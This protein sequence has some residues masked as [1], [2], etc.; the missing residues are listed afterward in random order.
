ML[1][2]KA[3]SNKVMILGV[4]GFDPKLA[5]KFVDQGIMPNLKK[6]IDQ[7]SCRDDLML[8]GGHP[9]IT[10]P[11]W[12]TLSTGAYATTHGIYGFNTH[13]PGDELDTLSYSLNSYDSKAEPLWDC[14]VEAGKKTLVWHWPGCSWPPTSDSENLFVI[15]GS[16]PGSVGAG[17]LE[18]DSDFLFEASTSIQ[19]IGVI[20][21]DAD[22]EGTKACVIEFEEGTSESGVDVENSYPPKVHLL[23]MEDN[24]KTGALVHN[25]LDV[26]QS[27]ITDAKNWSFEIPKGAKEFVLTMCNGMIRRTGLILKNENGIY[28]KVILYKNKKTEQ[29]IATMIPGQFTVGVVDESY[30]GPNHYTVSRNI[31]VLQ[32]SEDGTY[33]K[34]YVSP[35]MDILS[36]AIYSPKSLKD[37]LYTNIGYLP[38]STMIGNED[39]ELITD[40]MLNNWDIAVDWQAKAIN[41]MIDKYG[42]EAIFSHQHNVD[43]QMHLFVSYMSGRKDA[44]LPM[45]MYNKFAEDVY[46]QTDRYLGEFL[47]L[48]DE[49]WTILIVSD[50]GQVSHKHEVP[51]LCDAGG[52]NVRDMQKL[53]YT[54]LKTDENGNELP[55]IDWSKTTAVALGELQIY[56]NLKGRDPHGIV[57]PK[58]KYELEEQI[59]TDLYNLKD[60]ETGKRVVA[61]ALRNKDAVLLGEGGPNAGDIC[62]WLTEGYTFDHG[63]TLSTAS[64]GD[65]SVSPIFVAAG[66]GIK[67]DYKTTR[68][69]R[70]ADVAPTMAVIGGVR[71]PAQCEGAPVY[72][73]LEEEY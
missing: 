19:T 41:Y 57:D 62:Y 9:T 38:S 17:K 30:K 34:M 5:K 51:F 54:I 33:L 8:L 20:K 23:I 64:E 72:Q 46:K 53:G 67:K 29:P 31:K 28:D 39:P 42:I 26:I 27:P 7:G 59:I 18:K 2:N 40:C 1:R 37:E 60:S 22:F 14:F 47:H 12:T 61:L 3:L 65:T 11:M 35:G 58:E 49:D 21:P 50:H 73:I 52:V 4:D 16:A 36:D 55:E 44:R 66:K 69:I 15:D 6:Y 56:I 71:M 24:Q 32:L 45:E 68:I 70:E 25:Q 48:L 43:L 10:P 13:H 63:D